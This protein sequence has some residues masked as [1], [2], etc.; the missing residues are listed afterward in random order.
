MDVHLRTVSLR[1][2]QSSS[3]FFWTPS[4]SWIHCWCSFQ[5]SDSCLTVREEPRLVPIKHTH[6][7]P[8]KREKI[9]GRVPQTEQDSPVRQVVCNALQPLHKTLRVQKA[10]CT[11][12]FSF[13]LRFSFI[14]LRDVVAAGRHHLLPFRRAALQNEVRFLDLRS[15]A[16]GYRDRVRFGTAV[17]EKRTTSCRVVPSMCQAVSWAQGP[18]QPLS[19]CLSSTSSCSF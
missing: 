8:P 3:R 10:E 5:I 19:L 2:V 6:N 9:C 14:P 11:Q 15:G 16:G 7:A 18:D 1:V 12:G 4:R 17:H 13:A